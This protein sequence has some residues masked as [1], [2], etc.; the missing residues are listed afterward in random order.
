MLEIEK[1]AEALEFITIAE[2][3]AHTLVS[4]R[5]KEKQQ[6]KHLNIIKETKNDCLETIQSRRN[7]GPITSMLTGE[8]PD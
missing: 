2:R 5:I 3:I 7:S 4:S 6:D 8:Q 1:P